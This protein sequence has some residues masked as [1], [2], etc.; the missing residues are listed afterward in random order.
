MILPSSDL[1]SLG[2]EL[3]TSNME[4]LGQLLEVVNM[5]A[6]LPG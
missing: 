1:S 3:D 6:F 2:E 5:E 4:V